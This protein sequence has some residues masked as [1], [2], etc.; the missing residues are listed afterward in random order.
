MNKKVYQ[1]WSF[2]VSNVLTDKEID[3]MIGVIDSD[4]TI[5]EKVEH[6]FNFC[7]YRTL[8]SNREFYKPSKNYSNVGTK[9]IRSELKDQTTQ[10]YCKLERI[11]EY[12]EMFEDMGY[13]EEYKNPYNCTALEVE[14]RIKKLSIINK[15]FNSD[16][17][18]YSK[19]EVMLKLF[20]NSDEF[21]R[22]YTLFIKFGTEDETLD[23]IRDILNNFD[24]IL[25]QYK[26][27]ESKKEIVNAV[28]YYE[29][30]KEYFDNYSY[31]E[32]I[33][34]S[35]IEYDSYNTKEFLELLGITEDL[36]NYYVMIIKELNP[37]LYSKYLEKVKINENICSQYN[38]KIIKGIS[39]GISTGFLPDCTPFDSLEFLKRVPFK[40]MAFLYNLKE[41]M[42]KNTPED[43][44]IITKYMVDNKFYRPDLFKP[45]DTNTLSGVKI[46]VNGINI[47]QEE[48]EIITD[49]LKV[50]DIPVVK[51]SYLIA[52]NKYVNGEI[53]IDE[54]NNLKDKKENQKVMKKVLLVPSSNK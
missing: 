35:Y 41:F 27:L 52:R 48:N 4:L 51:A 13:A 18:D 19:V 43:A 26:E 33:I 32:F 21:R 53:D 6:L 25:K 11:I 23:G 9:Y 28:R 49:Y 31:A 38:K 30:H 14:Q 15:V 8:L 12:Y 29:C 50:N 46:S 39:S 1:N 36:F 2:K 40:D 45:F 16:L 37:V 54:I 5:E 47:G 10:L 42:K 20:K 3:Y 24:N 44:S 22:Q 7:N 17:D 34:D